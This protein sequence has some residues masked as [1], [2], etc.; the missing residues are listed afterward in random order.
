MSRFALSAVFAVL[1]I[2]WAVPAF[3][4]G[5]VLWQDSETGQLYAKPADGRVP[6]DAE[7]DL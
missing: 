3:C 1:T 2:L 4:E 5:P 6:V 7:K